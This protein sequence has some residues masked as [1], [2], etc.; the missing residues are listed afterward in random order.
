MLPG[1]AHGTL[2]RGAGFQ[3]VAFSAIVFLRHG[4]LWPVLASI[5]CTTLR[6]S[7][8]STKI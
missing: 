8:K 3:R 2:W 5:L 6:I 1:F 4:V 7:T